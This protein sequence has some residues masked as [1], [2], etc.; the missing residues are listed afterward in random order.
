M[1]ADHHTKGLFFYSLKKTFCLL[2]TFVL[3]QDWN[4]RERKK[5]TWKPQIPADH[6]MLSIE[7]RWTV[8]ER[9]DSVST[10]LSTLEITYWEGNVLR[11]QHVEP[12]NV[13]QLFIKINYNE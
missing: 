9:N 5:Q 1:I 8:L 13:N 2:L 7:S 4:S 11:M 3:S 6:Y 12:R 10:I